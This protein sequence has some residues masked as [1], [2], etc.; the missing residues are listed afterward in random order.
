MPGSSRRLGAG[1]LVFIPLVGLA[2]GCGQKPAPSAPIQVLVAPDVPPTPGEIQLSD[3]KVV[4][5]EP[6]LVQ[7]EVQYRFTKGQ[8]DKY[9][10]C[11]ISFPGTLNHGVKP[12]DSWELKAEGV[13]RDKVVLSK[14][15]VKSFEI[16]ISESSSPQDGYQKI[17][18]VVSGPVQ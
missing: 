1:C 16:Q 9:Y 13:I 5:L 15:G 12:M 4:F 6:T 17:S 10:A 2:L 7:F 18:N 11:D 14:P 8:P 3:P